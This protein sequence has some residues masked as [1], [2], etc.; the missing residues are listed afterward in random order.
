M[1]DFG[2][3]RVSDASHTHTGTLLGTLGYM[4]PQQIHGK[5][6]DGLSDIW[7]V[8][9]V[10]YELLTG[11]R[12]FKGG[13]QADLMRSIMQD[14]PAAL[15]DVLGGCPYQLVTISRRALSK[16]E[17]NRY[18]SME[19][20]L[21]DLKSAW[22]SMHL[23]K[24]AEN[25]APAV[26]VQTAEREFAMQEVASGGRPQHSA[27]RAEVGAEGVAC[28]RRADRAA[29]PGAPKAIDI[30]AVRDPG[31][32]AAA[33]AS[34]SE[35]ESE[36]SEPG[37][38]HARVGG[39]IMAAG[40]RHLCGRIDHRD[41]WPG[42]EPSPASFLREHASFGGIRCGD[43]GVEAGT[44]GFVSGRFIAVCFI[45]DRVVGERARERAFSR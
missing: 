5:R 26:G 29:W 22:A 16:N 39:G 31:I 13:N 40:N 42:S 21:L 27:I 44:G 20:L 32:C 17:A 28:Q 19:Q 36:F 33:G 12:P 43:A 2:I 4:S 14:E 9:V 45:E 35:R 11:R 1:V 41:H 18:Q 8:G 3:A 34:D 38:A 7:S 30:P 15:N 25:R 10:L 23:N 6:A 24:P 37:V